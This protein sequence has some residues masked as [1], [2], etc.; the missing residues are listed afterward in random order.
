MVSMRPLPPRRPEPSLDPLLEAREYLENGEVDE[1]CFLL[2][3]ALGKYPLRADLARELL[4]IYRRLPAP[5][6]AKRLEA[7]RA[8][9][10]KS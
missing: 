1:A 2:E 3:E 8:Q 4:E 6:V 5:E 7:R 9:Q 10:D